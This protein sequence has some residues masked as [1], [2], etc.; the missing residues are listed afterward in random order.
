[1]SSKSGGC[2]YL[3]EV[4]GPEH[5]TKYGRIKDRRKQLIAISN[6]LRPG[7]AFREVRNDEC[8]KDRVKETARKIVKELIDRGC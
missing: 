2:G 4:N 3:I 8:T 6:H 5:Y 7:I 1:L